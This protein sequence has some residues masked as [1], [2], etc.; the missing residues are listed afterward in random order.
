MSIEGL[1][2]ISLAARPGRRRSLL[3]TA[4]EVERLGFHSIWVPGLWADSLGLCASL[5]HV[6]H[7]IPFGTGVQPIYV[8]HP[9]DVAAI[10]SYV[11]ELAPGRFRLGLGVS[12]SP[13]MEPQGLHPA[14]P[15][16]EMR[17]YVEAIRAAANP[18]APLPPIV[19]AAL[20]DR[21]VDLAAE[22]AEGAVWGNAALS[23]IR[24]SVARVD[25][26]GRGEEF[27][28]GDLI[29][30]VISDDRAAA[31]ERC[32]RTLVLYAGLPNYVNYWRAA[33]W[34]DEMDA[35]EAAVA[36]RDP[37]AVK[38]AMPERWVEDVCLFGTPTQ[39]RDG[40]AAWYD[41]GVVPVCFPSSTSG[42][43]LQA[44]QELVGAFR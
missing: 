4:A 42:G 20:R 29:A 8:R 30:T 43:Q 37:E 25:A 1:P 44:I 15:R 11:N 21:M 9:A 22:V 24:R 28:R 26:A 14:K 27:F 36:T 23:D 39:V 16:S 19:L 33:G 12:H 5:A 3:E 6:T 31:L 7:E 35:L 2:A 18:E 41:A 38:A 17:A 34:A 10:A 13:M 40:I 32:R